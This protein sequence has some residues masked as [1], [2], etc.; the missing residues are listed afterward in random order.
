MYKLKE[1]HDKRVMSLTYDSEGDAFSVGIIAK[2][3]FSFGAMVDEAYRVTSGK[4]SF[5][6]EGNEKW[7]ECGLGDEFT[8]HKGKDFKFKTDEVS[9]YICYYK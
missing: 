3:E 5:W 9:S 1:Y 6:E 2:G 4:I 8:T 7:K